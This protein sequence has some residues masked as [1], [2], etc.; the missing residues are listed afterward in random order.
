[1]VAARQ[2]LAEDV[3]AAEARMLSEH[4]ELVVSDLVGSESTVGA[5]VPAAR[6]IV[7]PGCAPPAP[8]LSARTNL[9]TT[10]SSTG[11]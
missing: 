8:P 10:R 3:R 6:T 1:M 7:S 9:M 4:L 2:L 5:Y 11:R